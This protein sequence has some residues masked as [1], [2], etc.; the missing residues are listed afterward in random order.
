MNWHFLED[1]DGLRRWPVDDGVEAESESALARGPDG[2]FV[3]STPVQ[4]QDANH[5]FNGV[6]FD[7]RTCGIEAVCIK[8]IAVGGD[9]GPW[10][11][12]GKYGPWKTGYKRRSDWTLLLGQVGA[13]FRFHGGFFFCFSP[14]HSILGPKG[15][16]GVL[17]E[18]M[19]RTCV[20]ETI[21]VASEFFGRFVRAQLSAS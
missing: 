14:D 2:C 5:S 21:L 19:S 12:Y 18:R 6:L 20:R 9:I 4:P 3:L 15:G 16:C 13:M 1:D 10:A 17:L 7:V 11:V 8:K